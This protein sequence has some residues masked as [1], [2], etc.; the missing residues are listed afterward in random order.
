MLLNLRLQNSGQPLQGCVLVG[1]AD[2]DVAV[3]LLKPV[4][5]SALVVVE[6]PDPTRSV[7]VEEDVLSVLVPVA[8]EVIVELSVNSVPK[9]LEAVWVLM[10][11]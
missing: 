7:L 2:V 4:P 9:S 5:F 6:W 3:L 10:E 11:A 8:F 1:T